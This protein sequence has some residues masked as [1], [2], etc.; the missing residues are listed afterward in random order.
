MTA[1]DVLTEGFERV[2]DGVREAAAGLS[3]EQLEARPDEDANSIGWLLWHTSRV[4]DAQ[5]AAVAGTDEVWLSEGWVDRFG[6]SL[7][8]SDTGYGHD[9]DQVAAVRGLSPEQIV[10]Y[11]DATF[12]RTRQI[13]ADLDE[14]DLARVVD[15]SYDPPVTVGVRVLS[16]LADDLEHVGQAAYVRGIVERG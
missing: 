15:E 11:Q 5:M 13:L 3:A 1:L 12:E 6:L 10:G 9:H 16:I 14:A 7:D 2:R 4:Q 8:A